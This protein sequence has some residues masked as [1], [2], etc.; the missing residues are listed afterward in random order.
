MIKRIIP[1]ALFVSGSFILLAQ[2]PKKIETG[3]FDPQPNAASG[4]VCPP[5]A[6]PDAGTSTQT[7][8]PSAQSNNVLYLCLGD[9]MDIQHF[10]GDLSGDPQPLSAPG[11]SYVFYNDPPTI[12]GPNW[13]SILTDPFHIDPPNVTSVQQGVSINGDATFFNNGQVQTIFN[14]GDPMQVWFAPMTFDDFASFGPEQDP[15]TMELG[16]CMDVNV[17]DAFS[18]TYLNAIQASNINVNANGDCTASFTVTGGLPEFDDS[19]YSDVIVTLSTDPTVEADVDGNFFTHGETIE[20]TVP[21]PGIYNVLIEDGVSCSAFFTVDMTGCTSVTFIASDEYSVSGGMVCVE[22]SVEDFVD[23][24]NFQFTIN[25]DPTVL[26]Y[27]S[28]NPTGALSDLFFGPV[29][30]TDALTVSWLDAT[31]GGITIPDGS[32]IFEI[33]FNVIG[34]PGSETPVEFTGNLTEIEVFNTSQEVGFNGINGTSIVAG[35]FTVNFNSC[36]TLAGDD[37]GTIRISVSGGLPPYTYNWENIPNTA[38]NGSGT[39]AMSGGTGIVGDG[40]PPGDDGL[41]PGTYSVTVTDSN[42]DIQIGTVEVFNAPELLVFINGMPPSCAGSTDGFM[43]ITNSP[44]GG[45][46][47]HTIVWST[48]DTGVTSINNLGQGVYSVT[49]TDAAGCSQFA[50]N[51]L[52]VGAIM[53]DTVSLTHVTCNGMGSD[54]AVEVVASG[55]V[56]NPGSDYV[57]EWTTGDMGPLLSGVPDGAYCVFI[58]DDNNCQVIH[59]VVINPAIPPDIVS[60]D[61]V[62]VSCPSDVNGA[63]TVNA[64]ATNSPID[65][66]TWD[67]PSPGAGASITDLGPGT[68]YVTVTAEDGC[69]AVDSATLYAP[70]PL[71]LDSTQFERPDCPGDD[72]GS[73]TVFVSGGVAPYVYDWSTGITNTFPLLP[74]L[75]GDSTYTVTITD[76]GACDEELVVDI[77]LPDPPAIN[78]VF[79]DS[80]GV[81]CNGGVPCDGQAT[82]LASGGTAGTGLYNFNWESGESD[83]NAA[84]SSASQLCQGFQTLEV[85]DGLCSVTDSVMIT[86]PPPLGVNVAN[87]FSTPV[88]CNGLSDGEATVQASGGMPGYDYQWINPNVNGQTITG[89]PAGTYSVLITDTNGCT[90]PFNIEVDQP[91]PLVASIN[92]DNTEGISC[93]GDADGQIAITWTGGNP[94]PATY[95][96]TNNVSSSL[97]ATGLPSGTYFVTV[98]DQN[99]C[100]D[101]TSHTI[102]EPPPIV[103]VISPIEE[104]LCHGFQTFI[105]VDTAYGGAGGNINQYMFSVNGGPRRQMNETFPILAGDHIVTVYDANDCTAEQS[106]TVNQPTPVFVSL[107]SDTEIELGDSINLDPIISSQLPIEQFIWAPL[108]NLNCED[109]LCTEVWVSPVDDVTY[110]L[111]VVDTNGCEGFDDI[112]VE[113]D[114][115]R[116]VFIPNTFTP[117]GDGTNDFFNVHTGTGVERIRSFRVFDRWGELMFE[118]IDLIPGDAGPSLSGWDGTFK[119]DYMNPGVYVY[120]VEVEFSD[121]IVLLYRGDVT[122]L[123]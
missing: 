95:T 79:T 76:S 109:S 116:N 38:L 98:T 36:S 23:V 94:G 85:N 70:L 35:D 2:T 104:P 40:M 91:D 114:K 100:S 105:G 8:F 97:V 45:V 22:I 43:E 86:A 71:T 122:L 62:S 78:I 65:T 46:A 80:T 37:N 121:G 112:L 3:N 33:C 20:F 6:N 55:G 72:N 82:A 96:W 49:V 113:V 64:V 108:T 10:G 75:V 92:L 99:G 7:L 48:G 41:P 39:I 9:S 66:Y 57:Y 24:L 117:N 120:L 11:F 106:I 31:F 14:G 4:M 89:V 88:S 54:G 5:G 27:V 101:V 69:I 47:P 84:S 103:F 123:Y 73:V 111:T 51:G 56:I 118:A 17:D 42:G 110:T 52:Q 34:P 53:V 63:L 59:C 107:G 102:T 68:Y 90:F 29:T 83:L 28:V 115:N 18:V 87:T 67:P 77:F 93:N 50:Q 81:N 12:S 19:D 15:N 58:T 60:W 74:G 1:L 16:P 30:P 44:L 61:S 119:G 13:A 25:W 32:V 26:E 21:Q